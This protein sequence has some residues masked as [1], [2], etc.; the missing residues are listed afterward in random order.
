MRLPI[1]VARRLF[2][3]VFVLLGASV[4]VFLLTRAIPGIDPVVMYVGPETPL[5]AYEEIRR[6]HGLDRPLYEQYLFYMRDLLRGE[7][8]Y[9]RTAQAPVATVLRRLLPATVEL[10][11]S[12]FLIC[13]SLGI[14]LGI[15]AALRERTAADHLLRALSVAAVSVPS[16]F[17]G[18]FAQLVFFYWLRTV[19]LPHLPPS[20]RIDDFHLLFGHFGQITGFLI[21]DA[22]IA[23]DWS[24]LASAV[25]H[26]ILPSLT[27]ALFP[28]GL[29]V[30]VVRASALE[31]LG[32]DYIT[33]AHSKGLPRHVLIVKHLLKNALIPVVT[34]MGLIWG[35]LAGGS[36][37]VESVFS[38][39]GIGGWAASSVLAND[40]AGIMGFTLVVTATFV[41]INLMVDV[42][43]T[44]LDPR[45]R[46]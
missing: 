17:F 31:V 7:L 21:L 3:A 9:S 40:L 44:Y 18:L 28:L 12:A 30:R 19:G 15:Y 1:Y 24:A 27:L 6:R 4:L 2:F 25:Q 38:W 5:E 45:I 42:A 23:R 8:G 37:L 16:F 43:Y 34:V 46:Y 39:P 29:L 41:L 14:P 20:G 35:R 36:V 33:Y 32:A 13:V 26:L 10:T 11:L 22:I